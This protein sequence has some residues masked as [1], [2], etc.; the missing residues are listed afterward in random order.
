MSVVLEEEKGE[1]KPAEPEIFHIVSLK[2]PHKC[3]HLRL[4]FV[5]WTGTANDNIIHLWDIIPNNHSDH[6][7]Q[8]WFID[9]K[10]IRSVKAPNK[11]LHLYWGGVENNTSIVIWDAR[12]DDHPHHLNQEWVIN[13][14]IIESINAPGK[15]INLKWGSTD[16]GAAIV[17]RDILSETSASSLNQKWELRPAYKSTHKSAATASVTPGIG[18]LND[19][20]VHLDNA[21]TLTSATPALQ[22]APATAFDVE[23]AGD[24]G[25]TDVFLTHDWG[26]DERGRDTHARVSRVNAALKSRGIS[27]W[28]DDE[29]MHG[30][31][32]HKMTEGIDHASLIIVFIT[33]RYQDKVNGQD[34]RDN[35]KYE[36]DYSFNQKGTTKFIPVVMETRMRNDREWKGSLAGALSGILYVDMV[37]DDDATFNSKIDDLVAHIN[38]ILHC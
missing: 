31:I 3:I 38:R 11:C 24:L 30:D 19:I 15:A 1:I 23:L 32:R 10:L 5:N 17:L 9:G 35:C 28:F 36:F 14:D 34:R 20:E 6:L 16:N 26:K 21:I 37:E 13:K 33:S 25:H 18:C 22:I 27:T 8:E 2:A 29:Q 7:N 4:N 12:P